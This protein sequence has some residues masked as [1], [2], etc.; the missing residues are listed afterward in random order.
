MIMYN[1]VFVGMVYKRKCGMWNVL[2]MFCDYFINIFEMIY[3]GGGVRF[4]RVFVKCFVM[5]LLLRCCI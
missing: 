3:V 2:V 1:S 5:V 4:F